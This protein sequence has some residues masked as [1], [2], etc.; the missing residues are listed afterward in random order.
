MKKKKPFD[1]SIWT[2][3]K[4]DPW[5]LIGKLTI[6]EVVEAYYDLYRRTYGKPIPLWLGAKIENIVAIMKADYSKQN[7]FG[8]VK[9]IKKAAAD[10]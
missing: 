6:D 9:G 3:T 5:S 2:D 10:L 7:R 4:K 8:F 1:M